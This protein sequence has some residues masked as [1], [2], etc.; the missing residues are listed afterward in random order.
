MAKGMTDRPRALEPKGPNEAPGRPTDQPQLVPS[1]QVQLRDFRTLERDVLRATPIK[2][3]EY[4]T[5]TFN[6]TANADTDI[7]HH[8][9]PATPDDIDWQVVGLGSPTAPD[10]APAIYR[11]FSATRRAWG[12][13]YLILRCTIPSVTARLLLTVPVTEDEGTVPGAWGIP[14][15]LPLLNGTPTISGDSWAFTSGLKERGRSAR[16]GEWTAYTPTWTA[17]S[18]GA[19]AIGN[20]TLTGRYAQIGKLTLFEIRLTSGG[21]TNFGGGAWIF[22]LPTT[23][24]D[25]LAIGG[26]FT[27]LCAGS[28]R[29]GAPEAYSTSALFAMTD[30]G[31]AGI[32]PTTPAAWSAGTDW[33]HINGFYVEA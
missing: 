26:S 29:V 15:N 28:Y 16:M 25:T 8:L 23:M 17:Q 18:G 32:G 31:A 2:Q 9:R 6:S 5:V 10:V 27:A 19:P 24:A 13:G 33:L 3:F 4:V 22:S 20:G 12:D 21:T 7:R 30:G 14:A 11:D 1:P